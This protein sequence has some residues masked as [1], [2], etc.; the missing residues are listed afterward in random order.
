[1]HITHS[2]V[3]VYPGL[4]SQPAAR[5]ASPVQLTPVEWARQTLA[6]TAD[7]Q[8][9]IVLDSAHRRAPRCTAPHC[10]ALRFTTPH[11]TA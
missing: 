4:E 1:M 2:R 7:P 3:Q 8:Q 6:F 11:C 10:T 5:H 9:S